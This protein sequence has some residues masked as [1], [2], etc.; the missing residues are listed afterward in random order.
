LGIG[1]IL[2]GRARTSPTIPRIA[3]YDSE[4]SSDPL[5]VLRH[6]SAHVL[7]AAVT[8]LF[9][10]TKYAGGPPVEN[11]F[12]YDFDLPHPLGEHALGKIEQK[13]REIV[14]RQG[15]FEHVVVPHE[16]AVRIFE[17]LD[18]PY[19]LHWVGSKAAPG[20]EVSLYRTGEFVDLCRGPHVPD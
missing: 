19:K 16:E 18:Q 7:A 14:T 17:E 10:G 12:Y 15:P 9:P 20:E 11:G 2:E 13:R 4:A 3:E 6:S 5:Y 8:Q 1:V